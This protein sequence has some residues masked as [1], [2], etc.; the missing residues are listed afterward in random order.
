MGMISY[1]P[2]LLLV[3]LISLFAIPGVGLAQLTKDAFPTPA[4]GY[5]YAYE[6]NPGEDVPGTGGFDA[7][8]GTF[9]HDNGN[10]EW[11]GTGV[12]MGRPGGAV[13][14]AGTGHYLRCQ[15]TGDPRDYGMADPGSNRMLYFGH[16]LSAD[17]ASPALLD[18]GVTLHFRARVSTGPPVDDL[19]P[20][21]GGGITPYPGGGDGYGIFDGG[22]GNVGI[23]QDVGGIIS[24]S[25]ETEGVF[26]GLQ[27]NGLDGTAI[28]GNVDTGEGVAN[29]LGVLATQWHEYWVT[30]AHAP[31]GPGTHVV[32]VYIDGFRTPLATFDVTAGDA[33][34][35]PGFTSLAL[36]VGSSPASGA[37]DL[38]FVRVARGTY[39]PGELIFLD[40]FESGNT[41]AWSVT[42]R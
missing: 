17:G 26:A 6:A 25:L 34:P 36:G 33:A 35:F 9:S 1:R 22:R 37:I 19:H 20:D 10:D 2:T 14:L 23:Q 38:D 18:E 24:F 13:V 41:S 7:L 32:N 29:L 30:I 42:A 12:G 3:T 27:M 28:S 4:G 16:N 39:A 15:D 8:D 11:D 5:L 21:G 40:D 31:G